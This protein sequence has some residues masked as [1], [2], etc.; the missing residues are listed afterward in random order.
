MNRSLDLQL[1]QV[2]LIE[3]P[4]DAQNQNWKRKVCFSSKKASTHTYF[5]PQADKAAVAAATFRGNVAK[6]L[7]QVW[8]LFSIVLLSF[9]FPF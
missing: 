8:I 3:V 2:G 7:P 9:Q 4:Y 1:D 5:T 6:I